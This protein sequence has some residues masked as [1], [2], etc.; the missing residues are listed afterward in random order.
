MCYHY[1]TGKDTAGK[2]IYSRRCFCGTTICQH[3]PKSF[4][5]PPKVM[6]DIVAHSHTELSPDEEKRFY[7]K[8]FNRK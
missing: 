7:D 6:E 1:E 8:V 3:Q 2:P 5:Y 4:F